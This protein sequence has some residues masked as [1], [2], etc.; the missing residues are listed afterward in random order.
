MGWVI[1]SRKE[2]LAVTP[3]SQGFYIKLG[4]EHE[5]NQ[6]EVEMS[7]HITYRGMAFLQ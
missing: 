1:G 5:E 2:C 6:P 3:S 4:A 7:N